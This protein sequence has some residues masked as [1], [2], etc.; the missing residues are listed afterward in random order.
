MAFLTSYAFVIVKDCIETNP[1]CVIG[2]DIIQSSNQPITKNNGVILTS[3]SARYQT[4]LSRIKA[5]HSHSLCPIYSREGSSGSLDIVLNHH[6]M[7]W[8]AC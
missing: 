3:R 7:G 8:S 6:K 4:G 2:F 5:P 1:L